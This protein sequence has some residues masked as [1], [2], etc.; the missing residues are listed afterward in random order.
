[1]K[2]RSKWIEFKRLLSCGS[3]ESRIVVITCSHLVAFIVRTGPLYTLEGLSHD[4]KW[5]FK[6]GEDEQYPNLLAIGKEIVNKCKGVPLA[7]RTLGS[8]LFLKVEESPWKFVRDNEILKLEQK[9]DDI[10]LVLKLSYDE[11]PSHLKQYA[12]P[13][14]LFFQRNF[15]ILSL[16]HFGWRIDFSIIKCLIIK[17]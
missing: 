5:A 14:I 1:M 12:L 15:I 10:L 17:I 11:M 6:E 9:E 8:L 7:L 16:F 2:F 4:V 13:S 3:K